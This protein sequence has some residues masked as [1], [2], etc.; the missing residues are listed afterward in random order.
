MTVVAGP[1]NQED[2]TKGTSQGTLSG[3]DGTSDQAVTEVV[4][5]G[6]AHWFLGGLRISSVHVNC[7]G[8]GRR[9]QNVQFL[10]QQEVKLRPFL[11]Q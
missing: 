5:M 4:E 9:T 11:T 3:T 7:G 6:S 10:F 8:N 1:Q 2:E